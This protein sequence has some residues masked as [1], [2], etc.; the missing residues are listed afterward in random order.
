MLK[1]ISIARLK[2]I[3][4]KPNLKLYTLII[5][6]LSYFNCKAQTCQNIQNIIN[7]E[8]F[9][10]SLTTLYKELPKNQIITGNCVISDNTNEKYQ[11]NYKLYFSS[12]KSVCLGIIVKNKDIYSTDTMFFIKNLRADLDS[13]INDSTTINSRENVDEIDISSCLEAFKNESVKFRSTRCLNK[14]YF[15]LEYYGWAQ[16]FMESDPPYQIVEYVWLYSR[17]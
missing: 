2:N 16:S 5:F 8:H 3:S 9:H 10:V 4:S 13:M 17:E 7:P 14:N 12:E 15:K 1:Y 11:I 6:L